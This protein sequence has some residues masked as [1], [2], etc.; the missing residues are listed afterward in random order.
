MTWFGGRSYLRRGIGGDLAG[1]RPVR[2]AGVVLPEDGAAGDEEV[3]SGFA[4]GTDVA[5]V[6]AAVDLDV[7]FGRQQPAEL[8]DTTERLGHELLARQARMDAHAEREVGALRGVGRPRNLRFGI[9]RDA[10]A[11]PELAGAP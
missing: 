2:G 10:D 4:D 11:E 1:E 3:G 5:R 8:G 6:D 7:H 9:E